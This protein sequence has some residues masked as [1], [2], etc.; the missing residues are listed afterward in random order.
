MWGGIK[1]KK[2]LTQSR[3]FCFYSEKSRDNSLNTSLK[4]PS[5]LLPC[6][7]HQQM[8]IISQAGASG[9]LLAKHK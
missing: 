8:V 1:I 5:R 6:D 7:Y 9:Q 3:S 4:K 2:S